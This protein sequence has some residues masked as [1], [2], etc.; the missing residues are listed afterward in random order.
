[1]RII[2]VA[3]EPIRTVRPGDIV[4]DFLGNSGVLV[5][6]RPFGT[7]GMVTVRGYRWSGECEYVASTFGLRVREETQR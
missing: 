2:D 3:R 4:T 1:M 6:A 5:K 7:V